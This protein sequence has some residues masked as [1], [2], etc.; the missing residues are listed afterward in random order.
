M[1]QQTLAVF[2]V[3]GLLLA[4][5]WLLRR[6]GLAT[7]N[8]VAS[9]RP[10]VRKNPERRLRVIERVTLTPQHSLHLI[11]FESRPI[12]LATSPAGCH[13]VDLG[14]GQPAQPPDNTSLQ[15]GAAC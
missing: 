2:L 12:L 4:A 9:A 8:F 6:Q 5:L 15:N 1:L 14:A 7:F 10:M 3:L 13:A 11:S